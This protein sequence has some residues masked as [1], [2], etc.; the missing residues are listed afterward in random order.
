[1]LPGYKK[2]V[3]NNKGSLKTFEKHDVGSPSVKP[4]CCVL[5]RSSSDQNNNDVRRKKQNKNK[6]TTQSLKTRGMSM[7]SVPWSGL[8]K[9]GGPGAQLI[10]RSGSVGLPVVGNLQEFTYSPGFRE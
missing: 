3:S 2:K 1:M 7:E 10:C 9:C 5:D 4:Y 8:E 6:N